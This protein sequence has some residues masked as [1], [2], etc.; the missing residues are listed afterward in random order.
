MVGWKTCSLKNY[1]GR[2]RSIPSS[3]HDLCEHPILA[4]GFQV[5]TASSPLILICADPKSKN[6]RLNTVHV[7]IVY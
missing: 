3:V 2:P 5:F 6:V 1:F 7:I 4:F